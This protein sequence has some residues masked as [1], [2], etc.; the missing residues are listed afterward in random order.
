MRSGHEVLVEVDDNSALIVGYLQ[1]I[2][3][4]QLRPHQLH[5][6]N[7]T[8]LYQSPNKLLKMINLY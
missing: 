4:L 6:I 8:V 2:L 3:D 5:L 7:V 1:G